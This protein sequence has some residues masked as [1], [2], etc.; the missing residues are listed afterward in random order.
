MTRNDERGT[1]NDERKTM[2]DELTDSS[3]VPRSAFRVPRFPMWLDRAFAGCLLLLALSAPHSIAV[4]QG[5]WVLGLLLCVVRLAVRPRPRWTWTR[6]DAALLGLIAL[7][8][9]SAF[10]SYEPA[11]SLGKLKAVGLFT[12]AYLVA[13]NV[14]D[15]RLLRALVVG[16]VASCAVGVAYTAGER[17]VGRG[18][19]LTSLAAD[20]PLRAAGLAEG[21]VLYE[22]GG[23][24]VRDLEE[25]ERA[26]L[27]PFE[28]GTGTVLWPDGTTACTPDE[29]AVCVS[30]ARSELPLAPRLPRGE[31]LAGAT[32][33]A[34]LGVTEWARGR[35]WRASG[36]L[37]HYT[38]YAEVLQLV[39]SLALGLLV[40]RGRRRARV[41][42]ALLGLALAGIAA[43]LVLTVTRA[44]WLAFLVS[45]AVMLLAGAAGRRALLAVLVAAALV[46]P[47][48]LY[49]LR[50]K[51]GVG[52]FDM[53]DESTRWRV[54]VYREGLGLLASRPRH[55]LVGVGMDSLKLRR[56][57]WGMF[58]RGRLPWG[59]LHSTPLQIAF[60]RGVPALLAW[61][62]LLG[63]YARMLWRRARLT[64]RATDEDALGG[65]GDS[66]GGDDW[67]AR[68]LALGA[69]G[70]AAGFFVS[71]LVHY[72]LGDSEVA[73]VFYLV[74][75]L[76]LA[77]ERLRA[78]AVGRETVARER[79]EPAV[80]GGLM[81]G[82]GMNMMKRTV[83]GLLASLVA[84]S[85][86]IHGGGGVAAAQE[87]AA[88]ESAAALYESAQDYP[89][90][91][92][93]ELRA[94]GKRLVRED[95]QKIE[96]EQR[97]LAARAAAQLAARPGLSGLDLFHLGRLSN[98]ADKKEETLAAMRRFLADPAATELPA[99]IARNMVVVYAA[100]LKQTDEAERARSEYLKHEPQV[101]L[102][103][104]QHDYEL[105][106]AHLKAKHTELA[107]ERAR[108][109]FRRL[110]TLDP[111]TLP[112]STRREQWLFNAGVTLV[113]AYSA[114]KLKDEGRAAVLDLFRLALDLPSASLYR[115]IA[116]KY[117]DKKDDAERDLVARGP[118]T[119]AAPPELTVA[120]WIEGRPAKLADLRGRVV[121]IDFWYEWCGPCI[122]VFPTLR[123]WHK[124]WADEGLTVIGLTDVQGTNDER[125][126]TR[127]EK[128]DFLRKFTREHKLDYTVAVAERGADN[129]TA[130]GVSA[131]PT[132]VLLDRR[133]AVRYISIGS[134]PAELT[135]LAEM[136][137]KLLK[138]TAR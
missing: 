21:D 39:G 56:Q 1:R 20:S 30:G 4:S 108:E 9:V 101:P 119:R 26:L 41:G 131:Y 57:E 60:E 37:G 50:Q 133:G 38:T 120:E 68:G 112:A 32:P 115:M 110:K 8:V 48:G 105:G 61:L 73:L 111:K 65:G 98:L 87:P 35:D 102:H 6:V 10:L 19:K 123:G 81:V 78:D 118:E 64:S 129:L 137:E 5:A 62:A 90:R 124:K 14:R 2:N 23:R 59:H 49:V 67:L 72:N 134:N 116:A 3:P 114:A 17:A 58:D 94:K 97:E 33:A 79:G 54:T 34:R 138:E 86:L 66:R 16:L 42:T 55:L 24:R 106:L 52:L 89:R 130:Y 88:A 80:A 125:G 126:K 69:L 91:R 103:L 99:Q 46:A 92:R 70:G 84:A 36:L 40:A 76:A 13:G 83:S 12:V 109:A 63:L 107:V 74:M 31:L 29:R 18:V 71:G 96:S 25:V 117:P 127:A 95:F 22:V 51:R 100:Q 136:I 45:S 77:S 27:A 113:E 47:V 44:S 128:L 85:C 43:A 53:S 15:A 135:R 11:V 75:G 82:K 7:T 132:A 28:P 93:E 122:A 121:L 104:V